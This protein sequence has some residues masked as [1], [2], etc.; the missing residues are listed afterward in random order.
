MS[1]NS[2][3]RS[4][5]KKDDHSLLVVHSEQAIYTDFSS[6]IKDSVKYI[7]AEVGKNVIKNLKSLS[8]SFEGA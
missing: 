8:H 1:V 6:T 2:P 5:T 3:A 4:D 7:E